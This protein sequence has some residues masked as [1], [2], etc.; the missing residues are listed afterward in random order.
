MRT[1]AL[2]ISVRPRTP[3]RDLHHLDPDIGQDRVK[4]LGELPGSVT[5]QEP[6][7]RGA[8]PQIHQEVADLLHGPGTV[9]VGGDTENVHVTAADLDHGQAVQRLEGHCAVQVE[10]IGGEYRGCLRVQELPP[11]R[12]GASLRCGWDLQRLEHPA[13]SGRADPVA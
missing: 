8:A 1:P 12:V 7:I 4:R 3:R 9:R 10:E 2:G 6:E 11:G 5:D 13:D